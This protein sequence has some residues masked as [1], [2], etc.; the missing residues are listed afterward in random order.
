MF[1]TQ[2]FKCGIF[3]ICP[4]V[5]GDFFFIRYMGTLFNLILFLEKKNELYI[6]IFLHQLLNA[7]KR[8]ADT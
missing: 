1:H 7:E 3:N 4:K 2:K 8:V 5:V 6:F